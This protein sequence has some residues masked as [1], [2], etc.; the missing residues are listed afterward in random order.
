[1]QDVQRLYS[2]AGSGNGDVYADYKRGDNF[3]VIIHTTIRKF[4]SFADG[5]VRTINHNKFQDIL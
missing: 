5:F 1:M 2:I 3:T 4:G